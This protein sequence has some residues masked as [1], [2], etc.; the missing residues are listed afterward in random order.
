MSTSGETNIVSTT[1]TK[2]GL[3]SQT[4]GL[5]ASLVLFVVIAV[6]FVVAFTIV[7]LLFLPPVTNFKVTDGSYTIRP[8]SSSG[9][10]T[11]CGSCYGQNCP[12][13]VAATGSF[14]VQLSTSTVTSGAFRVF[15]DYEETGYYWKSQRFSDLDQRL[16]ICSS[17]TPPTDF[18][19]DFIFETI[20]P[21]SNTSAVVAIKQGSYA[22]VC[23]DSCRFNSNVI[24]PAITIDSNSP[25]AQDS[26]FIL[27]RE[28]AP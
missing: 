14:T 21:L 18:S 10:L 1:E 15:G 22:R 19:G 13:G 17:T 25:R 16:I 5:V 12:I 24:F 20:R 9:T 27:T 4:K 2:T 26:Q 7:Y 11:F 28:I 3:S 6:V 23:T 8:V